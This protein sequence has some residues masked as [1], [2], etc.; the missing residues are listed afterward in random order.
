MKD[1]T[2]D[3]KSP[4]MIIDASNYAKENRQEVD[5][6]ATDPHT[7]HIF[8]EKLKVDKIELPPKICEPACGA[9]YLSEE[10]KRHG[11]EV[12]L[13]DLY[14]HGYGIVGQDFLKSEIKAECFL[15]NPPYRF[16]VEFVEHAVENV[17]SNGYVIMLLKIQFLEGK[18]RNKFLKKYPPKYVYV[19]S[20]GQHCTKNGDFS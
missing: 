4:H 2:G 14:D 18:K 17:I 6:Y 13:Y 1:W 19:N 8:L 11:F 16:G 10:L 3:S 9:G 15:T 12:I 20:R 7:L 5:Y